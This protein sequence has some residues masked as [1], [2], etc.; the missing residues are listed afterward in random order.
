MSADINTVI[1]AKREM[2]NTITL[3]V[4]EAVNK[5]QNETGLAP[6]AIKIEMV[7]FLRVGDKY[8]QYVVA[9]T[10]TEVSI[11]D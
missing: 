9:N 4:S 5:F 8:K 6:H 3:T 7:E 11:D 2:E 1:K 10:R